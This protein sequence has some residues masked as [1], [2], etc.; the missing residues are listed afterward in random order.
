MLTI[1]IALEVGYSVRDIERCS[2]LVACVT[3]VIF[4]K[5]LVLWGLGFFDFL[6]HCTS[7]LSSLFHYFCLN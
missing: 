1:I 3:L 4:W 2:T 7:V 5:P 6:T